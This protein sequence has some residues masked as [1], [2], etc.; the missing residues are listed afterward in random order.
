MRNILFISLLTSFV[1]TGCGS[2][3]AIH[4]PGHWQ[5]DGVSKRD[6]ETRFAKCVYDVG[7]NKVNPAQENRLINACMQGAGFRW[8]PPRVEY[9]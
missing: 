9:R 2:I 1:L 8:V 7:M 4:I 6:T 5:Q 3:N